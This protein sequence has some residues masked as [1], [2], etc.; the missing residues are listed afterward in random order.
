VVAFAS[1]PRP[2]SQAKSGRNQRSRTSEHARATTLTPPHAIHSAIH[3]GSFTAKS[4]YSV[5]LGLIYAHIESVSV[6]SYNGLF[7]GQSC[8]RDRARAERSSSCEEEVLESTLC[9]PEPKDRSTRCTNAFAPVLLQCTKS[10]LR[11]Y[12]LLEQ[13]H[14]SHSI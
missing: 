14:R 6:V 13:R 8:N 3:G 1:S 2:Q 11:P 5:V 10:T 4:Y 9:R 7:C 12:L